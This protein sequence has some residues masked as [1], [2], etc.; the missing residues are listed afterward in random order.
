[1]REGTSGFWVTETDDGIQIGYEDY[2]VS[3]FGGGNFERTYTLNKDNAQAFVSAL[4]KE[5]DGTLEKMLEAA[6]GKNF[7][8]RVFW[9]FCKR[10][11]IDYSSSTWSG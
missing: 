6:F 1:M 7:S 11:E 3:A 8:D 9:D 5:Y 10:N 4:K 2:G